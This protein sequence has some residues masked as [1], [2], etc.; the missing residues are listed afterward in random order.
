MEQYSRRDCLEIKGIPL[1]QEGKEDTNDIV[2]KIGAQM[3]LDISESDISVSRRL[4]VSKKNKN[5]K[6]YDPAIVVKFVRRDVKEAYY[7]SRK[8]LVKTTTQDLGYRKSNRI[9]IN[10]NLTE[11]RKELFRDRLKFK[12][13]FNYAYI[14]TANGRIFM[15]KDRDSLVV[16]IKRKEDLQR[17]FRR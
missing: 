7:K 12:K 4:P 13:E 2:I 8:L 17:H 5:D 10:E 14:W 9:F 1:D 3:N 6:L 15:R 16:S 11:K